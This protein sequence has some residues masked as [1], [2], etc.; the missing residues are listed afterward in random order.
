MVVPPGH[1]DE[2]VNTIIFSMMHGAV[3]VSHC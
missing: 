1:P 2:Q 3:V